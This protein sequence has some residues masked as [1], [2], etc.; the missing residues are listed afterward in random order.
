MVVVLI[1]YFLLDAVAGTEEEVAAIEYP[2]GELTQSIFV[3][4]NNNYTE[5]ESLT[6]AYTFEDLPYMIDVFDT[7]AAVI[8]NGSIYQLSDT[9]F[10]YLSQYDDSTDYLNMLASEF[11]PALLITYVPE[12]T[13]ALIQ[14]ESTGFI[15]GFEATYFADEL[16]VTDGEAETTA[17]LLGYAIDISDASYAGNNMIVAVG[18]TACDQETIDNCSTILS[19]VM[20]TLRYDEDLDNELKAA[21]ETDEEEETEDLTDESE[22]I[23]IDEEILE[24]V[25]ENDDS[26]SETLSYDEDIYTV[27]I[28]VPYNYTNFSVSI[29]WDNS[30][31]DAVL[32]LFLPDGQSYCSPALQSDN[33]ATFA[34]PSAEAG[35]YT[36]R[37]KGYENMGNIY[38]G[39]INGEA[40]TDTVYDETTEYSDDDINSSGSSN[41][42]TSTDTQ[43]TI[44]ALNEEGAIQN[45]DTD[46]QIN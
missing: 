42:T 26:T 13:K 31:T 32:E 12:S 7:T 28:N 35:T 39:A 15:N 23:E 20:K 8:G 4:Q 16:Y 46:T 45:F 34:L 33:V 3:E 19:T 37:V 22:K 17:S 5:N 38:T 11:P 2:E 6:L 41:Y 21:K 29:S 14:K 36:L 9:M 18:T 44:D 24:N 43:N 27:D 10:I 40:D 30:Y 1:F 25:E